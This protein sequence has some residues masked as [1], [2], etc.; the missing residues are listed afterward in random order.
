[1]VSK[2][3]V[4]L[5][6]S[7]VALLIAL[8]LG[9]GYNPQEIT[10]KTKYVGEL[11][12]QLLQKTQDIQNEDFYYQELA[13]LTSELILMQDLIIC[14]QYQGYPIYDFTGCLPSKEKVEIQVKNKFNSLFTKSVDY[15]EFQGNKM[16]GKSVP[17]KLEKPFEITYQLDFEQDWDTEMYQ[18]LVEDLKNNCVQR[19]VDNPEQ[20]MQECF[21]ETWKVVESGSY[22]LFEVD[23]GHYLVGEMKEMTVKFAI[24]KDK[25][26]S[27][28]F[29][30]TNIF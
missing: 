2:K 20:M 9:F 11:Q 12:M 28:N 26:K 8:I 19:N 13:K 24:A 22:L 30:T 16:V 4:I 5:L 10:G 23:S 7:S 14:E 18:R 27:L 17:I 21:D 6:I 25:I 1:M 3:G 29:Q 15:L